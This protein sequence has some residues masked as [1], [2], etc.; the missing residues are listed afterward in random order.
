MMDLY[1]DGLPFG[2]VC[3]SDAQADG[4]GVITPARVLREFRRLSWPESPLSIE[5][6]G[7]RTAVNLP[8]YFFTDN[9]RSSRQTVQILGQSVEI[10]ATPTSYV[11]RFDGEAVTE[12]SSAGAPYPRG[13]VTH[14][15]PYAGSATPALDTVYA[16]RY[17]V[18]GG[19]W[20]DIPDTLTVAGTPTTL[21]I[22]E[23]RPT[24]VAPSRP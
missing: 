8:T 15:Y 12:T 7:A 1:R 4:L 9:T 21:E 18:N 10:E 24:L 2:Q 6:P 16:G 22:V 3:I 19:R 20:I 14:E 17:R 5:P 11:Y 13:D 23:V